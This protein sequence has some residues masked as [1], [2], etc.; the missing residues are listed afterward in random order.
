MYTYEILSKNNFPSS[1]AALLLSNVVWLPMLR[2][3]ID[4]F[5]LT[6]WS[7]IGKLNNQQLKSKR[8]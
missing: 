6:T 5:I 2:C 1:M 7:S 4:Y 3:V 8:K